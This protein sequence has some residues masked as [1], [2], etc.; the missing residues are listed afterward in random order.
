MNELPGESLVKPLPRELRH[1]YGCNAEMCWEAEADQGYEIP[2]NHF[3]IRS[4][5]PTPK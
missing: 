5:G 4:H 1:N 2:N 3:Y